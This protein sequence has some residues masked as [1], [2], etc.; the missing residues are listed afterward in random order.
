[1]KFQCH[2][3]P[4]HMPYS[5]IVFSYCSEIEKSLG[6]LS[7]SLSFAIHLSSQN[8]ISFLSPTVIHILAILILPKSS[9]SSSMQHI[10]SHGPLFL[11]TDCWLINVSSLKLSYEH[12][13]LF[14]KGLFL[15]ENHHHHLLKRATFFLNKSP[16]PKPPNSFGF[17]IVLQLTSDAF[18]VLRILKKIE[19]MIMKVKN[20]TL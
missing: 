1:M 7:F 13:T 4:S 10:D 20:Y 16:T 8:C 3:A 12:T 15:V 17:C 11:L 18:L 14:Q 2:I 9:F 5:K 6:N 19:K